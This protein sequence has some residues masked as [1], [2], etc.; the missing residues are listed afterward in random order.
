MIDLAYY[1]MVNDIYSWLTQILTAFFFYLF[2]RIF[3]SNK[4]ILFI[5]FAYLGT[6]VLLELII[7]DMTNFGVY[8]AASLTALLLLMPLNNCKMMLKLFV[9]ITYFSIRWI[10]PTIILLLYRPMNYVSLKCIEKWA[11]PYFHDVTIVYFSYT[12]IT[13]VLLLLL[14]GLA[15][16]LVIFF[17]K[18]YVNMNKR[19]L[20]NRELFILILPALIGMSSYFMMNNYHRVIEQHSGPFIIDQF[21]IFWGIHNIIVLLAMFTVL[22]LIQKLD[23][24]RQEQQKILLAENQATYLKQ[25]LTSVDALYKEMQFMKHD[26]KNHLTIIERLIEKKQFYEATEYVEALQYD[27]EDKL[28]PAI[29]GNAII[30]LLIQEKAKLAQSHNSLLISSLISPQ[31][32]EYNVY[33]LCILLHNSLDNALTA[34]Q[35]VP[36]AEILISSIQH[37]A[38][39]IITVT[40]PMPLL[41]QP[42]YSKAKSG[43]GIQIM[44]EIAKKYG[45]HITIESTKTHFELTILLQLNPFK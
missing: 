22:V 34:T 42:N 32:T 8:L 31:L 19:E 14:Y 25:H 30:D 17:Y 35:A 5:A 7:G 29:S 44:Q 21:L 9:V 16:G 15:L 27:A 41:I 11:A 36:E 3:I 43:L 37:K 4:Y 26:L 40:N 2:C 24:N 1:S 12:V 10:A 28:N 39:Y 45:G 23:L 33:D 18:K 13:V 38:T 6:V 20:S